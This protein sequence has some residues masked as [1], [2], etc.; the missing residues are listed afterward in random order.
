MPRSD[1]ECFGSA[2][3]GVAELVAGHLAGALAL[4]IGQEHP[5]PRSAAREPSCPDKV[6][7][8]GDT[9]LAGQNVT[10]IVNNYS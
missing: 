1:I 7:Y 8:N 2:A 4:L 10:V 9:A 5:A 3:N 6:C